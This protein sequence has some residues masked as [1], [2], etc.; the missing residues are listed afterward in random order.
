MVGLHTFLFFIINYIIC[1]MMKKIISTQPIHIYYII[2]NDLLNDLLVLV[3]TK[4][5][6]NKPCINKIGLPMVT[7][8]LK[9]IRSKPNVNLSRV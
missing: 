2:Y 1:I 6:R 8:L 3:N 4:E 7:V 9:G 5:L